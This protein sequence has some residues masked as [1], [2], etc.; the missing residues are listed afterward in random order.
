MARN[1]IIGLLGLVVGCGGVTRSDT[2]EIEAKGKSD[3]RLPGSREAADGCDSRCSNGASI[4][5]QSVEN[6]DYVVYAEW[7]EGT[8]SGGGKCDMSYLVP[9]L[10]DETL[11]PP[12]S[13]CRSEE[14]CA[15]QECL[16]ETSCKGTETFYARGCE[17]IPSAGYQWKWKKRCS[18]VATACAAAICRSAGALFNHLCD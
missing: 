2:E 17:M 3:R 1:V 14:D 18:D 16:C 10:N 9:E 7:S 15:W 11:S 4:G 12:G 13:A 6:K 5:R 8:P